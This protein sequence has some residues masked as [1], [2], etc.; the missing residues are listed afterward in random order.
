MFQKVKNPAVTYTMMLIVVVIFSWTSYG[1]SSLNE[2]QTNTSDQIFYD[3]QTFKNEYDKIN[4]EAYNWNDKWDISILQS[5]LPGRKII[6]KY[7]ELERLGKLPANVHIYKNDKVHIPQ[8]RKFLIYQIDNDRELMKLKI[9][10]YRKNIFAKQEIIDEF[11]W[12]EYA[13]DA[14]VMMI[15]F[16]LEIY[17]YYKQNPNHPNGSP[18]GLCMMAR[19]MMIEPTLFKVEIIY[20]KYHVLPIFYK[21]LKE[22]NYEP[23]ILETF[24]RLG[25]KEFALTEVLRMSRNSKIYL[26]EWYL[27]YLDLNGNVR[28]AIVDKEIEPHA[29]RILQC[30]DLN[31]DTLYHT[32]KYLYW[33]GTLEQHIEIVF[34]VLDEKRYLK[35]QDSAN[36][37]PYLDLLLQ[38]QN[39]KICGYLSK[40]KNKSEFNYYQEKINKYLEN[41]GVEK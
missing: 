9:E 18:K 3:Y 34:D 5:K 21:R 24:Y 27:N 13:K 39:D 26:D 28:V 16:L 11:Y 19:A 23:C 37:E 41:C 38:Y 12:V 20:Y 7:L 4:W 6:S 22:G 15:D 25:Y 31:N 36:P 30:G 35:R 1:D 17:T 33:L 40:K 8:F 32:L 2:G 29:F 14:N 10:D